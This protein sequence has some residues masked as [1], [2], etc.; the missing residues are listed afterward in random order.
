MGDKQRLMDI[1]SVIKEAL[2]KHPELGKVTPV[3][4]DPFTLDPTYGIMV[5]TNM[6][7]RL[8]YRVNIVEING[9]KNG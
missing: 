6:G 1:A 7:L 8:G 3:M 4:H 9:E 5:D 2:D